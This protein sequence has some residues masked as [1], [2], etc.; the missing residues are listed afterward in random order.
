MPNMEPKEAMTFCEGRLID[1]SQG[2]DEICDLT[3]VDGRIKRI[4]RNLPHVGTT[5][6]TT[7]LIICPGLID[8]HVHFREPGGE[9]KE[10]IQSGS[11]AAVAGGF[12][13]VVCMANTKEP[14]DSVER[15]GYVLKRVRQADLCRV[16]PVGTITKERAGQELVDMPAMH[17]AGVVAF[18]DDGDGVADAK[19]MEKALKTAKK[20]NAVIIQHCEVPDLAGDGVINEGQV[21][22]KLRLKGIPAKAEE[23]MIRRDL[24]LVEKIGARYHVAHI[25]TGGA[26]DLVRHA[27]K[28]G[29]PVTAEVCPHHLLLTERDCLTRDGNFKM[30]PPLRTEEDRQACLKGLVDGTIDCIVSDHAPH[31]YAEKLLG[32]EEAP[33][34]IVGLETSLAASI[35]ALIESEVLTYP[36]MIDLM[37]RRA[38]HVLNLPGGTLRL[39]SEA[40][41]TVLDPKAKWTVSS[42]EFL[43]KGRN[44]P[45]D[46][47]TMTGEVVATLVYGRLK[48]NS[49]EIFAE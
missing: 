8:I 46:E 27:K 40:D 36:K 37:S 34:G 12:T 23:E 48:F 35:R 16:A 42:R 3:I 29:L 30:K 20:L 32:L 25:S 17:A 9:E 21:S 1:P 33:F 19:I 6:Y 18:S 43:T 15:V 13:S 14:I 38:A 10:T 24:A 44:C 7:G 4:G 49:R 28:R 26:V 5:I 45:W 39:G 31:T 2:L 11:E 47:E 41:V 22:E